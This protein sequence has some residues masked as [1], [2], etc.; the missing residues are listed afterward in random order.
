[1]GH[2]G[3]NFI[4]K[5]VSQ[6]SSSWFTETPCKGKQ[7][8]E[9]EVSLILCWVSQGIIPKIKWSVCLLI[10]AQVKMKVLWGL[11]EENHLIF[12]F[13]SEKFRNKRTNPLLSISHSFAWLHT[14]DYSLLNICKLFD[15]YKKACSVEC[16][17]LAED[18]GDTRFNVPLS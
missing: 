11:A 15:V 9:W 18:F 16:E 12:V 10:P 3:R 14:F 1:M 2:I 17:C 4:S 7:V 8:G 6:L 5:C 13:S